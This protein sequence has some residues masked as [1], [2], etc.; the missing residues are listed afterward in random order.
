MHFKAKIKAQY[1][2]RV[3]KHLKREY[4]TQIP[5]PYITVPIGIILFIVP[6]SGAPIGLLLA[7]HKRNVDAKLNQSKLPN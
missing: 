7:K 1:Q 2:A 3:G 5:Y 4:F 6:L